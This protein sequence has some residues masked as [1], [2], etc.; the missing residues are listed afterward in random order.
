MPTGSA[1]ASASNCEAPMTASV[2]GT[3]CRISVSTSTRLMNEKPHS[4]RS[5]AASQWK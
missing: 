4:P 1:M 2:T 5:I 3:R